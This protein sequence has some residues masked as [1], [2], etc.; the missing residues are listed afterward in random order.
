MPAAREEVAGAAVISLLDLDACAE[1]QNLASAPLTS[2]PVRL[3]SGVVMLGIL[4]SVRRDVI[5]GATHLS[6][7]REVRIW[8]CG[9]AN[10][11][12]SRGGHLY[13]ET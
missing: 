1:P 3:G 10:K 2:R 9:I 5:G 6:R 4:S 11:V 7:R 12:A 8:C 13:G